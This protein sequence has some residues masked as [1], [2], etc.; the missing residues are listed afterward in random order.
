MRRSL[1]VF[2]LLSFAVLV[3]TNWAATNLASTSTA[4]KSVLII[5]GVACDRVLSWDGGDRRGSVVTQS[6]TGGGMTKTIGGSAVAPLVLQVSLPLS[7]QLA[8]L[9]NDLCSARFLRHTVV[10]VDNNESGVAAAAF[11]LSNAMLSEVT[12]PAFD[13]GTSTIDPVKLVFA[14][15]RSTSVTVP[16]TTSVSLAAR[17]V[18]TFQLSIDGVDA[19]RTARIEPLT[20]GVR[21]STDASGDARTY[22]STPSS[23]DF[24]TLR[25]AVS[26]TSAPSWNA[27][28][29]DFV[30]NGNATDGNE[31]NATLGLIDSSGA[32]MNIALNFSHV[33]ILRV[34]RPPG[35]AGLAT[36]LDT[37]MYFEGL[38]LSSPTS[39]SSNASSATEG[40]DP[41][42]SD[43]S[44]SGSNSSSGDS[45]SGGSSDAANSSDPTAASST[46]IASRAPR[47][48]DVPLVSTTT[49]PSTVQKVAVLNPADVGAHDPAQFPRVEGLTRT[50]YSGT[51]QPTYTSESANYTSTESI[52]Q[53]VARVDAAAKAAGWTM[54]TI[55][56]TAPNGGKSVGEGWT[57]APGASATV[58]YSQPIGASGTE[59]SLQVYIQL[60]APN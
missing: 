46:P 24:S 48:T 17:S 13:A 12:F 6:S 28:W 47:T 54:T 22:T 7:S 31:K 11:E 56:E 40:S 39:S 9:V 8:G 42:T 50:Y 26:A 1:P 59:F 23:V 20:I 53:L 5:D 18:S 27:W 30:L 36:K 37:E 35:T 57:K 2:A 19:S 15:E 29:T 43:S 45:G 60:P 16:G 3:S 4:G 32:P 10:L 55:T 52:E 34:S 41:S 38:S 21:A 14:A 49:T 44:S 25:V 33:G 58:G 51:F